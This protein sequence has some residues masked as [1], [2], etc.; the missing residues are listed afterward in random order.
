[1]NSKKSRP[2]KGTKTSGPAKLR[3]PEER[4]DTESPKPNSR[5]TPYERPCY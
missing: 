3:P 2:S 5:D 1:M 4:K